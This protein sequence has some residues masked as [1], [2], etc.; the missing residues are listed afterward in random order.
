MY[1]LNAPVGLHVKEGPQQISLEGGEESL[2]D[3]SKDQHPPA[4][5]CIHMIDLKWGELYC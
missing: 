4:W 5:L 3:V 1:I 2:Y